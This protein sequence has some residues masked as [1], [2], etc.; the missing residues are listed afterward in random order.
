MQNLTVRQIAYILFKTSF[1]TLDES[2]L[3]VCLSTLSYVKKINDTIQY[4]TLL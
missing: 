1:L 2:L 4:D 3:Y